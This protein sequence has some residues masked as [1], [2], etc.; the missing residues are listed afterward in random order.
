MASNGITT[1]LQKEVSHLQQEMPQLQVEL[2]QWDIKFD[3]CI[4]ELQKNVRRDTKS[5]LQ[6][7]FE[8]YLGHLSSAA[9]VG[10]SQDKGKGILRSPLPGFPSC[11][12]HM[13]SLMVELGSVGTPVHG[14]Q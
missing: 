3:N 11:N 1:R 12:A 6:S 14:G 7:L 2:S 8:Q 13:V 9:T 4:K 10:S 5:K